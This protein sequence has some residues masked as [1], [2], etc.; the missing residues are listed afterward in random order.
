MHQ[1]PQV[2]HGDAVR[3]TRPTDQALDTMIAEV[4]DGLAR[5]LPELP[6]KYFY[7]ERGC[8]LFEEITRLPEYYPARTEIGILAEHADAIVE[9]VAP[10]EVVE[11]G[12]G[13]CRKIRFFLDAVRYRGWL[14]S[15]Q[16]LEVS[17]AAL[18]ASVARLQHDY[19]EARVSGVVGDFARDL[20]A[21]GPGGGRLVLFL[22]GTIGNLHP[23]ELPSFFREVAAVLEP[24]DGFLVGVDLVKDE[25]RLH[26]AYNDSAGVTAE[27]N[28]NILRVINERL[29]ADFDPWDFDHRAFYNP[30]RQWIEMRL[31]AR[32]ALTARIPAA[33]VAL[34]LQAGDEI[35]TELSCKYTRETF[36][37]RLRGTGLELER[38][39]TDPQGLFA[40]VLLRRR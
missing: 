36:A 35:R 7:D 16:L 33:G 8:A 5:A 19:P 10:C 34:E 39:I 24:H 38:W 32:R 20:A 9:A 6:C 40:S 25:A 11:L 12:P 2:R 30:K 17:E 18:A 1:V 23:Q 28:R 21:L 15:V 13:A 37:A 27:F 22:A 4:R 31:R 14:E 26:A 29:G 3:R